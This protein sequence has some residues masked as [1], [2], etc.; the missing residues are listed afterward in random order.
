MFARKHEIPHMGDFMFV[1]K[2]EIPHMGDAGNIILA[3]QANKVKKTV[4]VF[5]SL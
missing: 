1:R 5:S 4:E 2:H 3:I